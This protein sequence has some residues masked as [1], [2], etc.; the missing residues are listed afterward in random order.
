MSEDEFAEQCA[1][2]QHLKIAAKWSLDNVPSAANG[3]FENWKL[4]LNSIW[5]SYYLSGEKDLS[6]GS[7]KAC[8]DL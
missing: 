4:L 1:A 2:Q 5:L 8:F 6:P 3:L 7:P